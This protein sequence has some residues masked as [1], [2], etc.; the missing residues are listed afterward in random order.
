[1]S[2]SELE[3]EIK[4]CQQMI[5]EIS[6]RSQDRPQNS[7]RKEEDDR[8]AAEEAPHRERM[9]MLREILN[10]RITPAQRA[11]AEAVRRREAMER[12]RAASRAADEKVNGS[13]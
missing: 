6:K 4:F 13:G 10:S 12:Y 11:E 8:D 2:N 5:R 9:R 3:E 7:S 1:M